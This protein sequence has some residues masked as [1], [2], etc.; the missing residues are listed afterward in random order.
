MI[1]LQ[2]ANRLIKYPLGVLEDVVLQAEK[3]F[4]PCNFIVMKMEEDVHTPTILRRPCFGI[5]GAM[6]DVKN[7]KLFLQVGDENM[8][9]HLP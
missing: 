3:F 5:M 7:N 4:I 6:I 9:L 2:L 1:S 8:E